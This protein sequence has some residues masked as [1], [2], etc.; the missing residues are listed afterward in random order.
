M[1]RWCERNIFELGREVS[2]VV[3]V[4]EVDQAEVLERAEASRWRRRCAGRHAASAS[5]WEEEVE[6][7]VMLEE[8]GTI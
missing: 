8:M 3:V 1:S 6:V 2:G 5:V 7:E 4:G